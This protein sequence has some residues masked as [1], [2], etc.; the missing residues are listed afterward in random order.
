[1]LKS[2]L[3]QKIAK[4]CNGL[5]QQEVELVVNEVFAT[6]FETME[7]GGHIELRGF[8]TFSLRKRDAR[9]GRNPKTGESVQVQP[10]FAAHFKPGK[11]LRDRVNQSQ[12]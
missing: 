12:A 9:T 11:D 3:I 5:T 10:K 1:M 4:E 7:N 2:E 6:M 8:G